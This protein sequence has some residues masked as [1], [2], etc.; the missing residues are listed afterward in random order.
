[1]TVSEICDSL[2]ISTA[3]LYRYLDI[4]RIPKKKNYGRKKR[5]DN[6]VE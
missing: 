4:K 2:G 6:G 3:T 5:N 1:M